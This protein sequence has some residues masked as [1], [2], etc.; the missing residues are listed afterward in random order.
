[1]RRIPGLYTVVLEDTA[2]ETGLLIAFLGITLSHAFNNPY[3]DGIASV[4]I[5]LLL[6]T[7]DY[8]GAGMQVIERAIAGHAAY[9]A[10]F[11]K[12]VLTAITIASAIK[13]VRS[14]PCCSSA[15]PSA[16][17]TADFRSGSILCGRSRYDGRVLRRDKFAA[18]IHPAGV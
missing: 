9:E 15:R 3:I 16:P 14:C 10:F 11:L 12:L 18:Y 5:S 6:G 8:N 7:R 17:P 13:A 2:A 1:M 4:L